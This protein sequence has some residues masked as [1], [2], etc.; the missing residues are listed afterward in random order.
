MIAM[1]ML[2]QQLADFNE[3]WAPDWEE[4]KQVKWCIHCILNGDSIVFSVDSYQYK[5]R[6]LSF[7]TKEDAEKF[8][9]VNIDEIELAKDFI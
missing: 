2:S 9:E 8:L 4:Y 7:R 3:G 6:F 1:A 5:P